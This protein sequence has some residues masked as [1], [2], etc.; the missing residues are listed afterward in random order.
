M[1]RFTLLFLGAVALLTIACRTNES[2]ERQVDDVQITA[3]VK[4]K[5]AADWSVNGY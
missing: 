1:K 2:P 3:Q 5:L 4:S